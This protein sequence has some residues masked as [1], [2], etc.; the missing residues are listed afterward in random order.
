[1]KNRKNRTKML[2]GHHDTGDGGRAIVIFSAQVDTPEPA[3]LL[4]RLVKHRVGDWVGDEA[5]TT[6][7]L[8]MRPLWFPGE[9]QVEK[10][11]AEMEEKFEFTKRVV[12]AALEGNMAEI[13]GL[14]GVSQEDA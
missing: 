7:M 4:G 2:W 11:A 3:K 9:L 12:V 8:A 14:A 13:L 5:L 1:M 10:V 6:S